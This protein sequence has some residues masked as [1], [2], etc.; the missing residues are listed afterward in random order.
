[1]TLSAQRARTELPPLAS[2]LKDVDSTSSHV[3]HSAEF[4]E[5]LSRKQLQRRRVYYGSTFKGAQIVLSEKF[6]WQELEAAGHI[7]SLDADN[8]QEEEGV[9]QAIGGSRPFPNSTSS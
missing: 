7:G 6:W 1:M 3:R 5:T 2:E 4:F 9:A 8:E